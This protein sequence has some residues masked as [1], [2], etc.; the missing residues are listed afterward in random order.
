MD[1]TFNSGKQG[2]N[3]IK[4]TRWPIGGRNP[5]IK[6]W[7]RKGDW[8]K[9]YCRTK[10]KETK[11]RKERKTK[12]SQSTIWNGTFWVIDKFTQHNQGRSILGRAYWGRIV[13]AKNARRAA[14]TLLLAPTHNGQGFIKDLGTP[15]DLKSFTPRQKAKHCYNKIKWEGGEGPAGLDMSSAWYWQLLCFFLPAK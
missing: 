10:E 7:Y 13:P 15:Q 9:Q 3:K 2:A 12:Q 6:W 11:K 4:A 5:K 14:E 1:M 8:S